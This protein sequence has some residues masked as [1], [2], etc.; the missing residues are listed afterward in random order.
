MAKANLVQLPVAD[1]SCNNRHRKSLGDIKSL[2]ESIKRVGLLHPIV[3]D[4]K[5]CLIAGARRL[6]AFLDLNRDTI[7]AYVVTHL[8]DAKS[9]LEAERDENTCRLDFT[10]SEAVAMGRA[11]E[12]LE[13]PKAKERQ[14]DHGGTAPGR[15]NTGENFTQVKGK[16]REIVGEA[17]GMSGPTYQRAKAVVAAA[18]Y[19]PEEFGP[20]LEE[21]DRTGKVLPA[22]EKVQAAKSGNGNVKKKRRPD[23]FDDGAFSPLCTQLDEWISKRFD[24]AGGAEARDECA[25]LV[26]QLVRRIEQWQKLK[27]L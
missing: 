17:I 13:R 20:V 2:A 24:K 18:E 10:P 6:E 3:V 22:F 1:I 9:L 16:T 15:K 11:L 23:R 8:N 26:G 12:E 4:G 25:K 27:P 7:P 5:N 14:K 21:M 19:D